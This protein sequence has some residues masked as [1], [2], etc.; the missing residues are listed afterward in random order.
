[1][2]DIKLNYANCK[3]VVELS[4][5]EFSK[6][7][8]SINV[9]NDEEL[10]PFFEK[11]VKCYTGK[12][13]HLRAL[14][15]YAYLTKT[16]LFNYYTKEGLRQAARKHVFRSDRDIYEVEDDDIQK[17]TILVAMKMSK[18]ERQCFWWRFPHSQCAILTYQ[19]LLRSNCWSCGK[20]ITKQERWD[21][22]LKCKKH[23]CMP[24]D[25]GYFQRMYVHEESERCACNECID[26]CS[27]CVDKM[28]SNKNVIK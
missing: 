20:L 1:M 19:M 13:L 24:A 6:A 5:S 9:W 21:R 2:E 28:L 17:L 26:N 16:F 8:R 10:E 14:Q 18:K 12:D 4:D 25:S 3:P 27:A 22:V 23:Q 7:L 11:H 15:Y